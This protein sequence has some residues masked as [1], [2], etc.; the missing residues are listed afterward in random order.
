MA[1]LRPLHIRSTSPGMVWRISSSKQPGR[2][3]TVTAY[4][5]SDSTGGGFWSCDLMNCRKF[6]REVEGGR[7]TKRAVT[8]AVRL[9]LVEMHAAGAIARK[10]A[11]PAA[12]SL[13]PAAA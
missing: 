8:D 4:E 3:A 12:G 6:R 11:S 1:E 9:L 7:A 13:D 2:P 5:G 10:D